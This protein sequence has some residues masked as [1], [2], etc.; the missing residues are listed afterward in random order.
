M[1]EDTSPLAVQAAVAVGQ[2]SRAA[3]RGTANIRVPPEVI[4]Y[5]DNAAAACCKPKAQR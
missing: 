4:L 2:A 5:L 1:S 3:A